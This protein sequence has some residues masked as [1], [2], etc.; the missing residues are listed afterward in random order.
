MQEATHS[1]AEPEVV[2]LSTNSLCGET[3]GMDDFSPLRNF[4]HDGR[5]KKTCPFPAC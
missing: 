1:T 3:S 5:A 4:D 2:C